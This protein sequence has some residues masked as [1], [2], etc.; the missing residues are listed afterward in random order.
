[1]SQSIEIKTELENKFDW[2]KDQVRITRENR[3]WLDVPADKFFIIFDYL[4]SLAGFKEL[5]TITGTDEGDNYGLMYH[6]A[7]T[8]GK[9]LNLKTMVPKE[10]GS[11]KSII[12]Y[13]PGGTIYER[14]INDLLG[15]K[16]EGLPPGRRYPLPDNWPEG[17]HPLRKGW[18]PTKLSKVEGIKEAGEERLNMPIGI[19]SEISQPTDFSLIRRRDDVQ[20]SIGPQHPALKEPE[21]FNVTLQGE[22]ISGIEI[23]L[24][25]NHRGIEKACEQRSYI[26]D[27]YLV[28]RICGIC[29]HTH[30]T[31]FVQAVEEIAGLQLPKRAAYIRTLVGELE[32]VHSHLLWLG[33]AG[34]E[35]GFDTLLMYTWRDREIV[36]DILAMLTGNRVNY[37]INQVGGVRRDVTPEQA[38][39]ILKA[40]DKLEEQT[41][42]YIE[43]ATEEQ[44]LI[45]RLS[46]V[47]KLS[48]EDVIKLGTVGP[49][50]RASGVERDIRRTDPYAAYGELDFKVITSDQC[51]VYG[52]AVVRLLELLESYSMIRQ[53]L[54]KLPD[55]PI[56]V[57]APRRIPV[58]EAISRYE[59][60]RGEDVHYVKS[61][62]TENPERVKV[63]APTLAN[64]QSVTKMLEDRYLADLP[65]VIAAIDPCFSCTDRLIKVEDK[66]LMTWEEIR[67]YGIE[68]Y[69]KQ[70]VD[71]KNVKRVI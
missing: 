12:S 37:G 2:L 42:Y 21:S 70:G 62:G 41:K 9:V 25:Y 7:R 8:D 49:T 23:K 45:Q 5:C 22:K 66:G 47:G 4:I 43:V 48:K 28:E 35:V 54:K 61:N 58:G 24:G 56:S 65:I 32:R 40:V 30:S 17:E 64:L 50:G 11:M 44:T 39:D 13:F 31:C 69:K 59:A 63:R 15:V 18:E 53:V 3:L 34:H 67:Q 27:V 55:G 52:R 36:M 16:F 19:R 57:R 46:G 71:F 10:G 68:W 26:Q 14:E 20:I 38:A 1:M 6:L 33:V 29:S 60:P 51:D